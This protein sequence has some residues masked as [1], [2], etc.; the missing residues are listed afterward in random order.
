MFHIITSIY[1]ISEIK[2]HF[3]TSEE[4]PL[5]FKKFQ[6]KLLTSDEYSLI[7]SNEVKKTNF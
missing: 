2:S 4:I 7:I 3:N 1:I 5:F 6:K